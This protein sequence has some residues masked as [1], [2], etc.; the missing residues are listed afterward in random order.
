MRRLFDLLDGRTL[1]ANDRANGFAGNKDS[2]DGGEE[3]NND[4]HVRIVEGIYRSA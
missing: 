1:L 2:S 4:E 3:K